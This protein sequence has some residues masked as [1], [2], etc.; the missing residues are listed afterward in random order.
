MTLLFGGFDK[1]FYNS[2]FESF[3]ATPG[4]ESR[5]G[6]FQLYPL[7]VHLNLFGGGY[8]DAIIRELKSIL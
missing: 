8:R 6:L 1:E 2:Y 3:P 7:L 5:I 4:W